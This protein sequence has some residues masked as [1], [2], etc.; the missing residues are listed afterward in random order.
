MKIFNTITNLSGA[1]LQAGQY[2][3]V[4]G[5]TSKGDT[6]AGM[7]YIEHSGYTPGVDDV[8]LGNTNVARLVVRWFDAMNPEFPGL[9][10]NEVTNAMLATVATSTIKG[11][12]SSGAGDVEDLTAAQVRTILGIEAG[13]TA[14]MTG[15]EI[16]VAYEAEAD[17][18]AFTD[19]EKTK[20]GYISVTQAVDLDAIE[21]AVTANSAKVTNATHTGDVTGSTALTIAPDVVT[22]AMLTNVATSTIKGRISGGTGD[23]EDL[24]AAQVRTL[25]NVENGAT[26][27]MSGAEIKV[28]YEAE[29]DTNAFTDAEKVKLAGV[30]ASAT[31]DMTGAE[32]K[33]AYEAEADTNAYDDAAK[34]IVD[35][36]DATGMPYGANVIVGAGELVKVKQL[37]WKVLTGSLIAR[38]GGLTDPTFVAFRGAACDAYA[39]S[40][41]DELQVWFHIPHDYALG[42]DLY[43]YCHWAHNGTS[44]TGDMTWAYAATYAKGHNQSEFPAEVTGSITYATTDIA[45]TPRW[46][47]RI[48][49]IQLTAGTPSGSQ[50][51]TDIIEVDG[52]LAVNISASAIPTIG[53]GSPN[54]PFLLMVD[55]HYQANMHGTLNKSPNF[56]S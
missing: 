30:E 29:A 11:R 3:G 18:N 55:L 19:A 1:K 41:S 45:T 28:A 10:P 6:G 23:P 12:A 49:E 9:S 15:A 37:V 39:F 31:T 27:D 24:T 44:I 48:D 26:A 7:Y 54:E 20:V 43:L 36:L 34:A 40:A 47:H 4:Y 33:V 32:I 2:V 42:T 8:I 17:T 46:R 13:A 21:S 25:I 52:L 56:Y 53:G 38:T 16:K 14:D 51:D 50:I 22:N 35:E 5:A